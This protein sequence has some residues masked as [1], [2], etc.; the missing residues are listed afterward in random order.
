ME[1]IKTFLITEEGAS[2]LEYAILLGIITI[3]LLTVITALGTKMQGAFTT[4]TSNLPE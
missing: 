4:A 2:L 1:K 3:S